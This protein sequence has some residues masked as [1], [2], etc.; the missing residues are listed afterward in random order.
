[1]GVSGDGDGECR[2]GVPGKRDQSVEILAEVVPGQSSGI[3][4]TDSVTTTL[5]SGG[6]GQSLVNIVTI[7]NGVIDSKFSV[8]LL[9]NCFKFCEN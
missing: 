6:P 3:D 5:S 9:F 7:N 4:D 8:F 2:S 1:M